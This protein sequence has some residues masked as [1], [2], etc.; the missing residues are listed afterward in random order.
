[1]NMILSKSKLSSRSEIQIT[2][3]KSETNRWLLLQALYPNP[4]NHQVYLQWQDTNDYDTFR[5]FD[6]QGKLLIETNLQAQTSLTIN[7]S[8]LTEGIYITTISKDGVIIEQ[9]KLIKRFN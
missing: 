9:R 6:L 1:M 8:K 5:L 4:A 7:T 2:G 3:S